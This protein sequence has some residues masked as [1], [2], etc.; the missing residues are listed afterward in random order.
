[1][2][3]KRIVTEGQTPNERPVTHGNLCRYKKTHALYS[4]S[5]IVTGGRGRGTNT[6]SVC[7][8]P[9][10]PRQTGLGT[11]FFGNFTIAYLYENMVVTAIP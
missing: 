8:E 7:P 4:W 9:A 1:V 3:K 10:R 11:M 5:L 6:G 2:N